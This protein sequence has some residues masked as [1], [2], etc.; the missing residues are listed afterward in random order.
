MMVAAIINPVF[1]R[2]FVP[3]ETI[4]YPIDPVKRA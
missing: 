1:K 4:P 2:P 3:N